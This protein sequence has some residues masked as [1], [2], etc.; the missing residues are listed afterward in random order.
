MPGARGLPALTADHPST[1]RPARRS[2][3]L[4]THRPDGIPLCEGGEPPLH[5]V[6]CVLFLLRCA[7]RDVRAADVG[8]RM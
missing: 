7:R 4:A 3:P 5:R 1:A 2:S 6:Y 8:P